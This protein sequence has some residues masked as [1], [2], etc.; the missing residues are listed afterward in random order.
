MR[1]DIV[2]D[3]TDRL[4][5][6]VVGKDKLEAL[7]TELAKEQKALKDLAEQLRTNAINQQQFD[8][9][10]KTFE[11]CRKLD[12]LDPSWLPELA[13]IYTQAGDDDKLLGVLKDAADLDPDDLPMRRKL[14]KLAR[15]KGDNA[16]AEKYARQGLEIDVLDKEC[17]DILLGALTAQNKDAE[18]RAVRKL[19][20]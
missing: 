5:I 3:Q 15:G 8:Q 20:E 14:A 4:I 19:L 17:Q 1:K 9:A 11:K 16:L 12:P 7:N 6:E 2:M 10:A 18:A 13:K